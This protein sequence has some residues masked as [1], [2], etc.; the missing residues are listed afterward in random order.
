MAGTAT[1]LNKKIN[2]DISSQT[3]GGFEPKT[4]SVA[5]ERILDGNELKSCW[6]EIRDGPHSCHFE[7]LFQTYTRKPQG[8]LVETYDVV[9]GWL[10]GEK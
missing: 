10:V 5:T 6:S 7:N 8:E 3:F 4:C 9:T 1:I 2:F